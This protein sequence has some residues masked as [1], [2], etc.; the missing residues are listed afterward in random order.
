MPDPYLLSGSV[1]CSIERKDPVGTEF[2]EGSC[3]CRQAAV[4]S[5]PLAREV[6][7]KRTDLL[8]FVDPNGTLDNYRTVVSTFVAFGD[9]HCSVRSG[10]QVTQASSLPLRPPRSCL[11]TQ[12]N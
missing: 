7:V 9:H 12:K 8:T 1:Q 10:P 6:P 4:A 5:A 11:P 2:E 3:P